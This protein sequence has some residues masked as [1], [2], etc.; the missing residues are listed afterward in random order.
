MRLAL[1][2]PDQAGNDLRGQVLD[3]ADEGFPPVAD[4]AWGNGPVELWNGVCKI[5]ARRASRTWLL[6]L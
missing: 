5:S 4:L 2:Q 3:L 1:F 6:G